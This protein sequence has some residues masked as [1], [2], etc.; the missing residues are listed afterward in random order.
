MSTTTLPTSARTRQ[1]SQ[2]AG[3]ARAWAR[4]D[5]AGVGC[6]LELLEHELAALPASQRRH[7]DAQ[8]LE[9]LFFGRALHE[10]LG[11]IA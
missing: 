4:I 8:F 1:L 11:G 5:A 2:P 7:P 3:L 6:S 9:G 10:R